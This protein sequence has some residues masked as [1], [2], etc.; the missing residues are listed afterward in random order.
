MCRHHD[1]DQAQTPQLVKLEDLDRRTLVR[2]LATGSLALVA[3]GCVTNPV[4]GRSQ[5][6]LVDDR[7][8]IG[9]AQQAWAQ[10]LQSERVSANPAYNQRVR[11]VGQR[12]VQAAG[13]GGQL[14]EFVVFDSPEVNAFVLP[15]G[16]VG[17]YRGL[18]EL[19]ASDAELAA[20]LGHEVAHTTL[21]H[22]AERASQ[23]SL[24]QLAA[25]VADARLSSTWAG[26]LGLGIQY[27]VLY[28]YSRTQEA[29][30]DRVG[31][32]YMHAAGFDVREAIA[33]WEKM[34]QQGGQRPPQFLST[35]PDP[36]NRI[37]DLRQYIN[38]RGYAL[39]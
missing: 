13:L 18:L 30:A 9:A 33:L 37:R 4:T 5:L 32:D 15:G 17:V 36:V 31:V 39:L 12:I 20:V 7:Q 23:Q 38:T 14:W 24:G 19:A 29:E 3:A 11:R 26:V 35:H 27:G 25:T 6:L 22:A 34:A 21:R 28:P 16:K 10:Q 2:G 8:L 1:E